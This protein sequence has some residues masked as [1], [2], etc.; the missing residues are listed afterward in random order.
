MW[1]VV[2]V[3]YGLLAVGFMGSVF[4]FQCLDGEGK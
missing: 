1:V 3:C 4:V 2:S